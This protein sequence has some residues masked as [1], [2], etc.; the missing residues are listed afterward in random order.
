[1]EGILLTSLVLLLGLLLD[2]GAVVAAAAAASLVLLLGLLL[3][4][5]AVVAAA[6]AAAVLS[7][8]CSCCW[9]CC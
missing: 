2:S 1:L 4:S 5:G 7:S 8:G 6:A 3:D 9:Y